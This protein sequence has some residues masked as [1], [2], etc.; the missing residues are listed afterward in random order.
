MKI[1]CPSKTF[2][3]GEYAVLN[4]G[5][6]ILLAT[7]PYF[8]WENNIFKD[9]YQKKGGFGAS[10]AK[11]VFKAFQ[12]NCADALSALKK[13]RSS[14]QHGSGADVVCQYTGGVTFYHPP[15]TIEKLHWSF[16]DLSLVLIH[17]GFKI[18]T[19]EHLLELEKN[20]YKFSSLESTVLEAYQA[21]I[22]KQKNQ[23]IQ[24]INQ[25]YNKLL[26]LQLVCENTLKL[27]D[28]IKQYPNVLAI[29]GCGA[30]GADVIL[31]VIPQEESHAF[32]ERARREKL[33]V[34]YCGNQFAEGVKKII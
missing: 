28:Q 3:L 7:E 24:C 6:A 4:D 19:H 13:F 30:L 5:P 17:T 27:I 1:L 14:D 16:T 34:I 2:L 20:F 29:K 23:F 9:P 21:I 11:F 12:E 15:Q 18:M 31:A 32:L 10:G 33:D 26:A 25:Y 22:Q 8:E